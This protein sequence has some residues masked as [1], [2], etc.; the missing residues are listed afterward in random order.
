MPPYPTAALSPAALNTSIVAAS[1]LAGMALFLL[2][3]SLVTIVTADRGDG[4]R[5]ATFET[6]RR[7][8]LRS[9]S[10][11]YLALE[12]VVDA[13]AEHYA[14]RRPAL[15][16]R[17]EQSLGTLIDHPPWTP[18]EWLAVRQLQ[19]WIW[20]VG[21]GSAIGWLCWSALEMPWLAVIPPL[22]VHVAATR[23][24]LSRLETEARRLRSQVRGLLPFAIDLLQ[25]M[26]KAGSS[27]TEA[28][29]TLVRQTH[30]SPFSRHLALL[31]QEIERGVTRAEALAHLH[32]RL[33]MEEVN[34]L[35]FSLRQGDELG[36]PMTQVLE[37]QARQ[38][39]NRHAQ[40][41]EKA[42]EQAKVKFTG[43]CT[44]I[45]VACMIAML[46]PWVLKVLYEYDTVFR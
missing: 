37:S 5:W 33:A 42:A 28:L 17:I 13:L 6:T 24:P 10:T 46:G 15:S 40:A 16:R 38:I 1:A 4:S 9:A 14:T 31:L 32:V 44:V 21:A 35:V 22:L 25:L 7:R 43:P 39:R 19:A 30:G 34:D 12:P 29:E 20:S 3:W 8:S 18:A 26:L 36:T 45:M 2:A 41:I 27:F 11:V 23:R